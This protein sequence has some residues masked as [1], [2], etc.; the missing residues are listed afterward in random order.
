M[1]VHAGVCIPRLAPA[2]GGLPTLLSSGE[3]VSYWL[4]RSLFLR[5]LG[6]VFAVAFSVALRQNPALIGDQVGRERRVCA[7]G[8]VA[9]GLSSP[10]S[11]IVKCSWMP[12]SSG[13]IPVF[14]NETPPSE[15]EQQPPACKGNAIMCTAVLRVAL[16]LSSTF[17]T[18]PSFARSPQGV[19]PAR[20]YLK[21]VLR[22][23]FGGDMR[24]AAK[25][26]PTLLWFLPPEVSLRQT[27][28][29][30]IHPEGNAVPHIGAPLRR[31]S[32]KINAHMFWCILCRPRQKGRSGGLHRAP[33]T[34]PRRAKVVSERIFVG[35]HPE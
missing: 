9:R 11:L 27:S 7:T 6:G 26:L 29:V 24:A 3:P 2:L 16:L 14:P 1:Y 33:E 10:S 17:E 34:A 22:N 15:A 31:V 32:E 8:L 28:L 12:R 20:D 25:R 13:R 5:C 18:P 4:T 30:R 23:G 35:A 19:T 21:R